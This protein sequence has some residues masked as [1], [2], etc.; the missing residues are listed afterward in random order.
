MDA[1]FALRGLGLTRPTRARSAFFWGAALFLATRELEEPTPPACPLIVPSCLGVLVLALAGCT[2]EPDP[3]PLPTGPFPRGP[4]RRTRAR[5][6]EPLGLIDWRERR[7]ARPAAPRT[8]RSRAP[9]RYHGDRPRDPLRRAVCVAPRREGRGPR[10]RPARDGHGD[11][12][13]RR[14]SSRFV[15]A[16]QDPPTRSSRRRRACT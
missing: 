14:P 1:S 8:G 16:F 7:G 2:A 13:A 4:P 12:R 9:P 10:E 3:A 11:R 15:T 5:H 6:R